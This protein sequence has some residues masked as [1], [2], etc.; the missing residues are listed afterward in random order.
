VNETRHEWI[1]ELCARLERVLIG[2]LADELLTG[3]IPDTAAVVVAPV[4][5]W[6]A[7][8]TDM[9]RK[10]VRAD[11]AV[12][13]M[14]VRMTWSAS[15]LMVIDRP[16][17][18]TWSM[19]GLGNGGAGRVHLTPASTPSASPETFP[20]AGDLKVRL[21]S[22]AGVRDRLLELSHDGHMAR[23][24]ALMS[25]EHYVD[26][27]V[28]S[29]VVAVSYDVSGLDAAQTPDWVLDETGTQSVVD[30]MLLGTQ[31]KP[32]RVDRL[33]E[34]CLAP[35]AF[36]RVDPLKYVVTDLHRSAEAEVRKTIGDPHIGRKIRMMHRTMPSAPV[37]DMIA[38][39][40]L[41]HP[42][43]HL[44][45]ARVRAALS[46]GPDL[47]ARSRCLSNDDGQ[48]P[49]HEDPVLDRLDRERTA[50]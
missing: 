39:Y 10:T 22:A 35:G 48:V 5:R 50:A 2:R 23:W 28:H 11:G 13:L 26:R 3:P 19:T 47:M 42:G 9:G 4:W 12:M 37:T 7:P 27:A 1:D 21:L 32:G 29:A 49:S 45:T 33:L 43:D 8:R 6:L 30:R 44:S 41:A 18:V 20:T 46:A 31:D 24:E 14:P 17:D 15:P 34:R 36:V 38:A 40:R 25:L 16:T